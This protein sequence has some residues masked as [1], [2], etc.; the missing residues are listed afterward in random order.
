MTEPIA[1]GVLDEMAAYYRARA[2]EYDEWWYRRGRYDHG[3]GENARWFEEAQAVFEALARTGMGGDVLELAPGTGIWTERVAPLAATVTAVDASPEMLALNR[4]R[5]RSPKVEYVLADLFRWQPPRSYDGV[6][7][8]FWISHVPLDRL[9]GFLATVADA[10]RPGGSVFFVD[11]RPE[12]R[13]T[14]ADHRLPAPASQTMTRRLNDGRAF[15][16]VKNFYEPAALE[17]RCRAAG[18]AVTVRETPAFFVYGAGTR[19]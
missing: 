3:P 17:A 16:I 12:P 8:A 15:Q 18:L 9:D 5:V 11:T 13:S 4:A 10:L 1:T 19:R 7:F 6:L 2:A 14:A